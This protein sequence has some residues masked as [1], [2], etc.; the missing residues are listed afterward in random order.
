M[1]FLVGPR[2]SGKTTKLIEWVKEGVRT[3]SYPGWSRIILTHTMKEAQRL[4][5]YKEYGLDYRQVFFVEEW[6]GARQ[7][8]SPVEV[9]FDNIDY[10]IR[11]I[12]GPFN[13]AGLITAT[14]EAE[15]LGNGVQEFKWK[16]DTEGKY[17]PER[18]R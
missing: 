10:I 11:D 12:V 17:H 14:G 15:G 7:G 8:S 13:T 6:R 1:K 4:R 3:D 16:P 18:Y 9:G 5:T 2:A